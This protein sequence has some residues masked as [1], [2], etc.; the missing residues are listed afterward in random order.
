MTDHW[1]DDAAGPVVRPYAMT[2]GRTRSGAEGAQL[3]LIALVV[4]EDLGAGGAPPPPAP[5][6]G[7]GA[8]P[9]PPPPPP[10]PAGDP[11]PR[12]GERGR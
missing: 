7:G 11:A 5:G 4:A 9:A 2:R 1:F 12:S 3:D 6:G 8:P 10:P